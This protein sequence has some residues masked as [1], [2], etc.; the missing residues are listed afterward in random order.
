[1][2]KLIFSLIFVFAASLSSAA[3]VTDLYQ[4]QAVVE[5]QSEQDR[6]R[7]APELLKQVLIKVVGDSRAVE[8]ADVSALTTDAQ[9]YIDQFFY[10]QKPDP[11]SESGEQ[12]LILTVDFNPNGINTA[13][14]RIG[15][16][17][18]D[19][20]RPESLI[21]LA[22]DNNGN[23]QLVGE[24]DGDSL[25]SYIEQAAQQRGIP[26][27]L[28]LMDLED[29]TQ[30]TFN[31]VATGNNNAIKQ[32][33]ERYA[34]SVIVTARLRGNNEAA[35]ISWQAILGEETERWSSQGAVKEAIQKGVNGLADRLGSRLN[36]TLSRAGETELAIQISGV[37]DY[38]GYTRLMDYLGTLQA[39]TDIKVGSLGSEKLDLILVIQAEPEKFR[40]LLSLGR[41]VQADVT[42]TTGL[43]YRLLP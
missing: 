2:P 27:L 21:W 23:Q 10:Q 41:V 32:A 34:P 12:Q 6:Q 5:S 16:P 9:R 19:R 11:E 8:Q 30:L 13:L 40:Q 42:D 36:M 26:I 38:E 29:Q 35:E 1:M 7:L 15:L 25:L 28:P 31:D 20:I 4:A 18:W 39:V 22:V 24:A 3:E 17:V 14:Q 37:Q 33:S 43:Q